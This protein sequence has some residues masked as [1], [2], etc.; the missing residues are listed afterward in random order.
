[1]GSKDRG[2][3]PLTLMDENAECRA[4][5]VIHITMSVDE[6]SAMETSLRLSIQNNQILISENT[7]LRQERDR[8]EKLCASLQGIMDKECLRVLSVVNIKKRAEKEK[9]KRSSQQVLRSDRDRLK[10]QL[11]CVNED[12]AGKDKMIADLQSTVQTL[13]ESLVHTPKQ[14]QGQ[15]PS[16]DVLLPEEEGGLG[17]NDSLQKCQD[18]V[19]A[20]TQRCTGLKNALGDLRL[21]YDDA[22]HKNAQMEETMHQLRATCTKLRN[23]KEL[24]LQEK[25]SR[26]PADRAKSNMQVNDGPRGSECKN[27]AHRQAGAALARSNQ[28]VK[29]TGALQARFNSKQ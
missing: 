5:D 7:M 10:R 12:L 21:Q 28:Q 27:Q 18:Q 23:E 2:D 20:L 17:Y 4:S 22:T 13:K 9:K 26:Q 16:G 19:V 14:Q 24:L 15:V 1:M 25:Q 6:A 29:G 3:V 11:C 8:L